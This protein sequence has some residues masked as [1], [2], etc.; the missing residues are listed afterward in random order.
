MKLLRTLRLDPSDEFV[1]DRAAGPGEWAVTGSGLFS[2]LD[3]QDAPPKMR[4]AFRAGFLGLTSLGFSTLVEVAEIA[5]DERDALLRSFAAALV[6]RFGAPSLA[7]AEAAAEDEI[8][9]ASSLCDHE[10]GTI[11]AMH[12]T[13]EDGAIRERFRTLHR[14]DAAA[15]GGDRLHAFA[16]AFEIV[17]TDEPEER[18]DL[19]GLM[20]KG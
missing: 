15:P 20:D 2:E 6:D 3:L 14:R 8:V 10:A 7:A 4:A 19:L 18:V 11:I 13:L 1:F 16:R 9:F 5:T 12:R 17:E